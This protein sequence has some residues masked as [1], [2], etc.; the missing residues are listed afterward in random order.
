MLDLLK[1]SGR[2]QKPSGKKHYLFEFFLAV[3][4]SIVFFI[5]LF[6]IILALGMNFV[7]GLNDASHSIATVVATKALSPGTRAA[8]SVL[9]SEEES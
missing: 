3:V 4:L 8:S 9:G 6:G 2:M 1:E 5:I 7:N